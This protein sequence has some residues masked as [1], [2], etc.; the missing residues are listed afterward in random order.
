MKSFIGIFLWAIMLT[1]A[2]GSRAENY[3]LGDISRLHGNM[4]KV[5]IDMLEN[6]CFSGGD[7]LF[8]GSKTEIPGSL[9]FK[10]IFPS[11]RLFVITSYNRNK[12]ATINAKGENEAVLLENCGNIKIDNLKIIADGYFNEKDPE[13]RKMRCGILVQYNK[14]GSY[15]NILIENIN[16]KDVFYENK[17]FVRKASEVR[18]ANGTQAYGWGIRVINN[19]PEAILSGVSIR[20]CDIS[21][22][23]H[24][25]IKFSALKWNIKNVDIYGN[26]VYMTGGPGI[27]MSGVYC[28]NVHYNN[29]NKSGSD[30]DTRK[31]GRGSGYWCWGS[32]YIVLEHNKLMNANGPGDS[33]GAHIDYNCSDVIYQYN[34]SYNNA[35][36]FCEIL[37][38]NYNCVYRYNISVNDGWRMKGHKGAFHEGK[39]LWMSGYVGEKKRRGPFNSYVYNNTI[40]VSDYEDIRIAIGNTTDGLLIANNIFCFKNSKSVMGDQFNPE[41]KVKGLK[42]E[43]IEFKNNLFLSAQT[44]NKGIPVQPS[45]FIYGNPDFANLGGCAIED[46]IPRNVELIKNKGIHIDQ[47]PTDTAG[48]WMGLNMH[49]D[50]LGKK[51][52][53]KPDL[54]AVEL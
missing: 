49:Y 47:L 15:S 18:T 5:E 27:Q 35:G 23:S 40:V 20:N 45:D 22:V 42:A 1:V 37:G 54:G 39:V 25:G 8:I 48:V 33:S 16:I 24:T 14:K 26:D 32:K 44:W 21:N 6:V 28:A 30:D 38:N 41:K 29:I 11:D 34:F 51:I 53:G 2:V 9:K 17:G 46:Y 52:D 10:N 19:H 50:I 4:K 31:W 13:K 36:G 43:H 3:Y 7:T 12:P